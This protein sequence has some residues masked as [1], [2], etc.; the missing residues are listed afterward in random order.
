MLCSENPPPGRPITEHDELPDI[1][2][3]DP[4]K[5][6]LFMIEAV[7]SHGPV[8]P[9]RH[10]EIEAFLPSRRLAGAMRRRC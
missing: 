10:R 6:W 2:L 7:T 5:Q 9:K 8:S 4:Q 3:Y 1:V